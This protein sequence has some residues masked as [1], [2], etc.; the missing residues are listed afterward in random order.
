MHPP[1]WAEEDPSRDVLHPLEEDLRVLSCIE[2]LNKMDKCI[3]VGYELVG[4]EIDWDEIFP[5]NH[6][7]ALRLHEME[8]ALWFTMPDGILSIA[9]KLNEFHGQFVEMIP[10][11]ATCTDM[12]ELLIVDI[13]S[14]LEE[15]KL[16]EEW[17]IEREAKLAYF[18]RY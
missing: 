4:I 13:R 1:L 10:T 2:L 7:R 5:N 9:H 12:L 14:L 15:I 18:S 8:V 11:C 16:L 17:K 6:C 3:A